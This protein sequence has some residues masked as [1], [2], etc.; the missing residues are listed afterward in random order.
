MKLVLVPYILIC[1]LLLKFGVIKRSLGNFV[2][3]GIGGLF[4]M[5]MVLIMSRYL[6]FI[7]L[8]GSS[9]IKAPH[10]V[11]NSPAGGEI[12][13][14]F[15]THNQKVKAGEPIYSFKTDRYAIQMQAKQAEI[16]RLKSQLA[17]LEND[18][19]RLQGLRGDVVSQSEFDAKKAEVQNQRELVIKA[20]QDKADLQWKIDHALVKAPLDGQVAVVFLSEGQYFGESRPAAIHMFTRQ[21][22][23]EVR[24]PDQVYAYIQP[25]AF[26]E[27]YVD[28]YP[29]KIF[30][31]RVHSVTE[32]TGESQ[33]SLLATPQSVAQH[34]VKNSRDVGR[35][36]I[37]EFEEPEG[38]NIPVGATGEAWIAAEKPI[39]L[40][41]FFDLVAG[42][43]LRL[44]AAETYLKAM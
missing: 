22:F 35:T 43:L 31:A 11:L 24:I 15:V 13:K 5:F 38:V 42:A 3:M 40:L 8:T 23:M 21:K 19:K 29:G 34:I 18:A 16:S 7:D 17:K 2:A 44:H 33:G 12:D 9:T 27:F 32:S 41:G 39:H 20:E 1:W 10:I 4:L 28:A 25:R 30:R 37:L 14:I 26:A 36:V 6:A